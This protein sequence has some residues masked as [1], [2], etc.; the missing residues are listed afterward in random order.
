MLFRI[1][2]SFL[3]LMLLLHCETAF[4]WKLEADKIV[5][6]NTTGDI[7]THINFRQTY[8]APPLVLL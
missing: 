2:F 1:P 6:R 8:A 4:G 3:L 5:V 7:S